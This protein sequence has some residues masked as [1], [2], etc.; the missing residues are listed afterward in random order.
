MGNDLS[1]ISKIKKKL[2]KAY[3]MK[4]LGAAQYTWGLGSPEIPPTNTSG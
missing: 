4:D 1:L 3:H 2:G